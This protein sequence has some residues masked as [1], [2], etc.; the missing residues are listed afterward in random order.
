MKTTRKKYRGG[1]PPTPPIPPRPDP[2]QNKLELLQDYTRREAIKA[3]SQ[4]NIKKQ[5]T[6][7]E[8]IMNQ[9][10]R[11]IDIKNISCDGIHNKEDLKSKFRLFKTKLPNETLI[12]FKLK[13]FPYCGEEIK[14]ILGMTVEAVDFVNKSRISENALEIMKN[15]FRIEIDSKQKELVKSKN[16]NDEKIIT[17]VYDPPKF[18]EFITRSGNIKN[19]T[20]FIVTHSN[21]MN[22][23]L[24]KILIPFQTD[25][26]FQ[27]N[28]LDIMQLCIDIT[29]NK[30]TY[31]I[32]RRAKKNYQPSIVIEITNPDNIVHTNLTDKDF[33]EYKNIFLMRHCVACHNIDK[34]KGGRFLS[35]VTHNTMRR[36]ASLTSNLLRFGRK[37][38]PM[39]KKIDRETD[40]ISDTS[41]D[42]SEGKG[43][44]EGEGQGEGEGEG[45]GDGYGQGVG[46]G[47]GEGEGEGEGVGEGQGEG[48]GEGE[49]EGELELNPLLLEEL[50]QEAD[51]AQGVPKPDGDDG[52]LKYAMCLQ[53]TVPQMV[54]RKKALQTILKRYQDNIKDIQFGSS[55]IF[56]AILTCILQYNILYDGW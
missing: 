36:V 51:L 28:N 43:E 19:K 37:Q 39:L 8:Q 46:E 11:L 22:T 16:V 26:K 1:T 5:C 20:T 56:R 47:V 23:L 30:I 31:L 3:L 14:P 38:K 42:E 45:D 7:G 41:E 55:V 6:A 50:N 35:E 25:A 2:C 29:T 53:V 17:S 12:E 10:P 44:G 32:I 34:S 4:I 27:F 40:S 21:F 48:Q 52:Y 49:G 24:E 54:D 18:K 13:L 15:S 33:K 9:Y